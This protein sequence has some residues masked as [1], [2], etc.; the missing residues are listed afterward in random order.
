MAK[1]SPTI[2]FLLVV[3]LHASDT[4]KIKSVAGGTCLEGLGL[5]GSDCDQRCKSRHPPGSSSGSCD[6]TLNP[7]LCTCYYSCGKQPPAPPQRNCHGGLGRCSQKCNT[8]CCNASCAAKFNYGQGYCDDSAGV[9]ICQCQ[10]VC[11]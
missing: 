1:L 2:C 5:C 4:L 11:K 10:Y 7:P 6:F 8:K 3:L 9:S